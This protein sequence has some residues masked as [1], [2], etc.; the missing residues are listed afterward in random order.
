MLV[1][2]H[3]VLTPI[4]LEP[5]I[6]RDVVDDVIR[7]IRPEFDEFGVPEEVLAELQHVSL[8]LK[9]SFLTPVLNMAQ[10]WQSKVVASHV[11]EFDNPHPMNAPSATHPATMAAHQQQLQQQHHAYP[12]HPVHMMPHYAPSHNPYAPVASTGQPAVKSEPVESRY[13][14]GPSIPYTLPALP[15]PNLNNGSR[16]LPPPNAV[17]QT[18]VLNFPRNGQPITSPPRSYVP[19]AQSSQQPTRIPQ[20]DGPSESSDEEGSP[21][22]P[23]SGAFAPR[24]THP[25]LPQPTPPNPTV[26]DSEAIN[27]DLDDS[28]TENED[29]DEEGG[30][31]ETDI[32]FC[33]YDKV[34]HLAVALDPLADPHS[35]WLV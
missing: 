28:D 33:T 16:Q 1:V 25:S 12:P 4:F 11:A 35:R 20:V 6:Y 19:P 23:P 3:L 5:A 14:L 13:M 9:P 29:E 34:Y 24:S 22:P 17:G 32:V 26:V 2:A 31:G 7:A 15:G 21:S 8:T 27:S 18:S 30:S 10:K